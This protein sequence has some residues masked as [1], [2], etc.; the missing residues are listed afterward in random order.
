M[1]VAAVPR[2]SGIVVLCMAVFGTS[3]AQ[4][5]TLVP[6]GLYALTT[7][8]VMPHL[9]EALRYATV[10]STKCLTGN[11]A[12][13]FFPLLQHEALSGCS[14]AE[15][16]RADSFILNCCNPEAATGLAKLEHSPSGM[17]ATLELKMGG[18]NMTLS[19]RVA[20]LRLGDCK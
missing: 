9:E 8:T 4:P 1:R 12:E 7:E 5:G 16:E 20:G 6:P 18:K 14:L 17:R 19:Q 11:S 13:S 3:A 2:T 10:K 15:T